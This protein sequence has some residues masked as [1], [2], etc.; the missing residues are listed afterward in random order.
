MDH[1]EDCTFDRFPP[2]QPLVVSEVRPTR[3]LDRI[4]II[5]QSGMPHLPL[6]RRNGCISPSKRTRHSVHRKSRL[7]TARPLRSQ[8]FVQQAVLLAP[9][10]LLA[11]LELDPDTRAE[12][13]EVPQLVRLGNCFHRATADITNKQQD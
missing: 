12:Q 8:R 10:E 1:E 6:E 3:L 11:E 9:T 2:R 13:L 5:Q 7:P 4:H